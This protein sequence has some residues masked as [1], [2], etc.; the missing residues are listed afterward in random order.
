[1]NQPRNRDNRVIA[2][3]D[4]EPLDRQLKWVKVLSLCTSVFFGI[5]GLVFAVMARTE[6]HK[7]KVDFVNIMENWNAPFIFNISTAPGGNSCPGNSTALI[8]GTWPGTSDG[9]DCRNISPFMAHVYEVYSYTLDSGRCSYNESRAGCLD[10]PST[11]PMDLYRW[12]DSV[13]YCASTYQNM[14]FSSTADKFENDKD[15]LPNTIKC[16]VNNSHSV[17]LPNWVKDCPISA[18]NFPNKRV[19]QSTSSS[20]TNVVVSR[21]TSLP[22]VELRS[23]WQNICYD[24]D[25]VRYP[26]SQ[27][28]YTLFSSSSVGECSQLDERFVP[29]DTI[30]QRSFFDNNFVQYRRLPILRE[31]IESSNFPLTLFSRTLIH[32]DLTC[33]VHLDTVIG[34]TDDV[35]K[36][37]GYQDSLLICTIINFIFLTL[38]Y[39][40]LEVCFVILPNRNRDGRMR[41]FG[42]LNLP[43]GE[44]W[45]LIC[46]ATVGWLSKIGQILFFYLT[47][48]VSGAVMEF[49]SYIASLKCSDDL[50]NATF[51]HVDKIM[52]EDAYSHNKQGL[53]VELFF[54]GI[55]ILAVIRETVLELTL[56]NRFDTLEAQNAEN[57]IIEMQ[58]GENERIAE[59]QPII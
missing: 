55:N 44:K 45:C 54:V 59:A 12:K 6:I 26:S 27:A 9:C 30:N 41:P 46:V 31:N 3:R 50:T 28:K 34:H 29:L 19:L 11:S 25:L 42:I 53:Y 48:K 49:F 20:A 58:P 52:R 40:C 23:G 22:L 24:N 38:L 1:M 5:F 2:I 14:S 35:Q 17:C 51:D 8:L 33:R 10:I 18:I 32:W 16:G 15:C 47:M 37:A 56:K 4:I 21:N 57:Q 36:V 43:G 7:A 13:K 39:P